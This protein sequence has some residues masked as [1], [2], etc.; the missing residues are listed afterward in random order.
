MTNKLVALNLTSLRYSGQ[1]I[2]DNLT[3]EAEIA[4][5]SI[6]VNKKLAPGQIASLNVEVG[7]FI[8]SQSSFSLS[9]VIRVIERDPVFNDV[10]ET[11]VTFEVNL[12]NTS[13]QHAIYRVKVVESAGLARGAVAYFDVTLRVAVLQATRF[14]A[15]EGDGWLP[16]LLQG[17][18]AKASLPALLHVELVQIDSKREI[19]TIVEGPYRGRTASVKRKSDGSSHLSGGNPQSG[20]VKLVY[21]ISRKTLRVR[22][23]SWQTKDY[24]STPWTSGFYDAEIPDAPHKGGLNYPDV[25]RA[26]T[27]FRIGH[28]SDRYIHT[29]RN[30]LGC[31]TVTEHDRWDELYAILVRA[32]KGDG[33]SVGTLEVVE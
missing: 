19:F 4:G 31:I 25:T 3:I 28:Q 33:R 5:K 21:S 9:G 29:G 17:Q 23:K 18:G 7:Q 20:P 30:S 16:V 8:T 27:W 32:R 14:V 13:E 1:S 11:K 22:G 2:G 6:S 12:R 24:P 15:D 10:G 26:K